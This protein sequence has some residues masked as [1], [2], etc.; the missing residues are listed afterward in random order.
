MSN[1]DVEDKST[2]TFTAGKAV[3]EDDGTGL[4]DVQVYVRC[5]LLAKLATLRR[6]LPKKERAYKFWQVTVY[7]FTILGTFLASC[8]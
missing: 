3:D 8:E 1:D 6:T 4:M 5:R 2:K 7:I